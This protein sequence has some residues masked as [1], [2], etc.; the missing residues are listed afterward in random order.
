MISF[1]AVLDQ[2]FFY[3][4]LENYL[5][6]IGIVLTGLI[7][8]RFAS[9]ILSR[10]LFRLFKRF[11]GEVKSEKFVELLIA[12]TEWLVM[13]L[14]VYLA[15]SR[16]NLPFLN[17]TLLKKG[18]STID[19]LIAT[20]FHIS[21]VMSVTWM[22][23]RMVDFLALV[24]MYRASLTES[25]TDDQLVPFVK[26]SLK[27]VVS[28]F[29]LFFIM[30]AVFQVNVA[31]LVGGLGIGGL[32]IALAGKE[33]LENL[34]GSITIFL[35]KPFVVGDL[36]KVGD[37]EGTVEQVGFRS[38][39]IRTLEKS[40][41]TL[42]NRE[43]V[44]KPLDNLSLRTSRRVKFFL[45][46]PYN[47]PTEKIKKIIAEIQAFLDQ[48]PMTNTEAGLVSLHTFSESSLDIQILYYINTADFEPYVRMKEHVGMKILEILESNKVSIAFPTRMFINAGN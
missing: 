7:F 47:T 44:N 37:L 30:G 42:P 11:A 13:L 34:L 3:N 36:V 21:I 23:Y 24:L 17:I 29:T 45:S 46:I 39:R 2:T 38:T 10:L 22:L 16:L 43:L 27:V 18:T 14:T 5:W 1:G 6:I 25:K 40:Y 35:D 19:D 8:K 31:A 20:G 9:K 28:I 15:Y 48:N 32:A 12:P 41:V 4:T 33:S 26:D